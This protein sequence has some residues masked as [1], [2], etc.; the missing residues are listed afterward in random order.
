MVKSWSAKLTDSGPVFARVEVCYTLAD[1]AT[2][3]VS[4]ALAHENLVPADVRL[5][6]YQLRLEPRAEGPLPWNRHRVAIR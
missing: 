6:P 2:V 5:G 1:G 3:A 4:G